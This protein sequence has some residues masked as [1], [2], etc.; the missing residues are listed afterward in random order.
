MQIERQWALLFHLPDHRCPITTDALWRKLRS[1]MHDVTKRTVE[2]DLLELEQRFPIQLSTEG[3]TNSWCWKPGA[4]IWLPGLNETRVLRIALQPSS[5]DSKLIQHVPGFVG[6]EWIFDAYN[7]WVEHQPDS[8]L[9]WIK[10]GPGVGKS[11]IAANLVHRQHQYILASWFCDAK[12]SE[13]KDPDK[14]IKSIAFQLALRW[15]DYRIRL[16][17]TLQLSVNSSDDACDRARR[18]IDAR[19]NTQD[20]FRML[21]VEP[22]KDLVWKERKLVIVIDGLDEATDEQGNNRITA[23]IGKELRSLP[24]WIG[25]IVTSRPEAEVVDRLYGFKPFE[26]DAED[27]RNLADLRS[28]YKAQLGRR[29]ELSKLPDSEQQ[30]IEDLLIERSSGMFLYLKVV[31]E[32]LD[33]SSISVAQIKKQLETGLSGLPGLYGRYYD[34]FQQRFGSDYGGS[35]KPFLRLLFAAGGPLPEDLACEVLAWNSE[36]FLACRNRLGSYVVEV[37][38]G[39]E[40][41]HATLAEWLGEKSSGPFHLDST[42]GRRMLADVLFKE[43]AEAESHQVRWSSPICTWLPTWLPQLPQRDNGL[44]LTRLT[45]ILLDNGESSTARPIIEHAVKILEKT[46]GPEHIDTAE[47]LDTLATVMSCKLDT[48]NDDGD[49]STPEPILRRVL[50]IREKALGPE[51]PEVGDSLINL[52]N[53]LRQTG[54]HAEAE[55]LYRRALVI[56]ENTLEPDDRRIAHRLSLLARTLENIGNYQGAEPLYRRALA[57]TESSYGPE[58]SFT[59]MRS[60]NLADLLCKIGNSAEAEQL[61]RQALVINEKTRG[62]D[63]NTVVTLAS[64]IKLLEAQGHSDAIWEERREQLARFEQ[65]VGADHAETLG[66]LRSLAVSLRDAGRLDEAEPLYRDFMARCIRVQGEDSPI[67]AKAYSAMGDLLTL[68]GELPEAETFLHKARAIRERKLGPGT[69]PTKDR[70]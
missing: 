6:R 22:M 41:F 19:S 39:Y 59:L 4:K 62:A 32:D 57:I 8:R 10:A 24:E 11:A 31:E 17:R 7:H 28:W 5:F 68:K 63:R 33:E 9:F 12:S 26:I 54:H 45:N 20:L 47:S 46:R 37:P 64:L 23:L 43:V 52:A 25:F 2:R 13:L 38:A 42:V 50:G 53:R 51:H 58:S 60:N 27:S 15:E 55:P 67:A 29:P 35:V 44:L 36:Q 61:Y 56:A 65:S 48:A 18:E 69:A 21:L 30:R 66:L 1:E 14:A 16:M 3:R 34:G 49:R 40:L 70:G